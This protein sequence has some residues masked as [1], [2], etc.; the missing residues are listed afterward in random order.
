VA[1]T[2][3]A[4]D[5]STLRPWQFFTLAALLTSTV[6]VVLVRGTTPSNIILLCLTIGAAALVG[7]G[8]L[9]TL[10]PL[11]SAESYEPEMVGSRTRAAL[12]R[13]KNLL[14]R[15]IKEL[16]FD[17]AMGKVSD[18][19][20]EEMTARLRS[21]AVRLIKQL[22]STESG[23]RE[24]IERELASRLGRAAA[25]TPAAKSEALGHS[26]EAAD[27]E[28][29]AEDSSSGTCATCRTVNDADARFC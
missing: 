23:Y 9:R 27:L 1:P 12:E 16:E 14:L 4:P 2:P 26:S 3:S 24:L 5:A 17:H 10:R 6:A 7:L 8:A 22:D 18:S 28:T 15:S 11:L 20:F 13:E 21:R 25:S 19:D 29:P